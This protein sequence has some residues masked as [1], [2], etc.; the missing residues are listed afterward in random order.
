VCCPLSVM[1]KTISLTARILPSDSRRS[2]F[3]M[4]GFGDWRLY[5]RKLSVRDKVTW[6]H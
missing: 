5:L 6:D 4:E 1:A 2:I 3:A